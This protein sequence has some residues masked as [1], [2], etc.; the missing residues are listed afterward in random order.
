VKKVGGQSEV[1]GGAVPSTPGRGC[2]PF[3]IFF[4]FLSSKVQVLV[5][6]GANFIAVEHHLSGVFHFHLLQLLGVKCQWLCQCWQQL[7]QTL[8]ELQNVSSQHVIAHCLLGHRVAT[9]VAFIR[10][11]SR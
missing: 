6:I 10:R 11:H 9:V 4:R 1:W 2:A 8:V 3:Q 7:F 5:H